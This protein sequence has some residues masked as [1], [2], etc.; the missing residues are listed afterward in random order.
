MEQTRAQVTD[1]ARNT[2]E[3]ITLGEPIDDEADGYDLRLITYREI[4]QTKSR[5]ASNYWLLALRPEN[6]IL[7]HEADADAG[8]QRDDDADDVLPHD[9]FLLRVA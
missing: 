5:T 6:F 3:L 9:W 2:A 8:D 7:M 4:M 1:I